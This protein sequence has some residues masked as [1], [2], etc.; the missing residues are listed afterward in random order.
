MAYI[1]FDIL[2]AMLNLNACVTQHTVVPLARDRNACALLLWNQQS[3]V[4]NQPL[5]ELC[6]AEI[7][8][9]QP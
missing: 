8:V 1:V 6:H 5:S 3:M 4:A 2:I 9:P 7:D